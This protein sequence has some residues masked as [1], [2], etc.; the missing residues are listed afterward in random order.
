LESKVWL[1][2]LW[3]G[4]VTSCFEDGR[5]RIQGFSLS[6]RHTEIRA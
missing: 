5:C 1:V 6:V 3:M 4:L 2:M